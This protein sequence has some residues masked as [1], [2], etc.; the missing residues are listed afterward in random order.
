MAYQRD[1]RPQLCTENIIMS[2][3]SH[4]HFDAWQ[5]TVKLFYVKQIIV[6]NNYALRCVIF[7]DPIL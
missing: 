2:V 5:V 7:A 4:F 1:T 6:C 3:V